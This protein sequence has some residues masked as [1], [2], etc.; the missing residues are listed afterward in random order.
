[1]FQNPFD[2]CR[3]K[4]KKENNGCCSLFPYSDSVKINVDD[5]APHGCVHDARAGAARSW[6]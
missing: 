6:Q 3:F 5:R 1:M 4:T 2:K